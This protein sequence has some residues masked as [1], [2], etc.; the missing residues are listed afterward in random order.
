[1]VGAAAGSSNAAAREEMRALGSIGEDMLLRCAGAEALPAA[2]VFYQISLCL[3]HRQPAL[4]RTTR[5]ALHPAICCLTP[6]RPVHLCRAYR[7]HARCMGQPT[8]AELSRQSRAEQLKAADEAAR[9][10]RRQSRQQGAAAR[11]QQQQQ[12]G[13]ATTAAAGALPPIAEA[14]EEQPAAPA[15]RKR[16][17]PAPSEAAPPTTRKRLRSASVAPQPQP[18]PQDEQEDETAAAVVHEVVCQALEAATAA[19]AGHANH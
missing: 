4:R 2:C 15:G 3:H 1:M 8:M 13:G 17:A 7:L 6:V 19:D 10:Q 12:Q 16:G 9:Q 5:A 18:A 14:A 11:Q